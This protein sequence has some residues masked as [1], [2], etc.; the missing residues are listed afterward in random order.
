[1]SRASATV[2][3]KPRVRLPGAI[4]GDPD[5]SFDFE[6]IGGVITTTNLPTFTATNPFTLESWLWIDLATADYRHAFEL[7]DSGGSTRSS[8]GVYVHTSTNE[9]LVFERWANGMKTAARVAPPSS[10]A[11][12]HVVATY[13]GIDLF[14]YVDSALAATHADTK[15]QATTLAPPLVIGARGPVVGGSGWPGRIDEVA[16]YG[17][18]LSADRIRAHYVAGSTAP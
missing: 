15:A 14:L 7:G 17:R 8:V 16:V 1:V 5:T 4:A 2:V 18:A 3:S 11:W 10:Q 12:H 13:D 9:G 6:G